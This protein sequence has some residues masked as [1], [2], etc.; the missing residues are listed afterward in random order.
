MA[1]VLEEKS[2]IGGHKVLY[3]TIFVL[4]SSIS[5]EEASKEVDKLKA[6]LQREGGEIIRTENM[7][8]KK[9]A[10]EVRKEKRGIY[11]LMHYNGGQNTVFELQRACRLNEAIIK[12]MT[13]KIAPKDLIPP[14]ETKSP[15]S[16]TRGK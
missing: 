5:D 4:K 12:F 3:E 2:T 15:S 8:R 14:S 1:S 13:V 6:I 16:L 11:T 7:G 10:Y 9:L